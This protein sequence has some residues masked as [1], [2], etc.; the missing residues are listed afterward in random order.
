MTG[1]NESNQ[2]KSD[3]LFN[4]VVGKR[5]KDLRLA[6]KMT[7]TELAKQANITFQ[8][9]QKY[10]MGINGLSLYRSALLCIALGVDSNY[11][12]YK[13]LNESKRLRSVAALSDS[14]TTEVNNVECN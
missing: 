2:K 12:S 7:Q 13:A 10:E 6:R 5:L 14:T 1:S 11:F 4:Q 3:D 8:Q 9:I